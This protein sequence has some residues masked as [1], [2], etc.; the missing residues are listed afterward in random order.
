MTTITPPGQLSTAP[1]TKPG[2]QRIANVQRGGQADAAAKTASART[3]A[4]EHRSQAGEQA[5]VHRMPG[6][7]RVEAE[8]LFL[9]NDNAAARTS[10]RGQF[11]DVF[12]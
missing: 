12:T 7:R 3:L 1:G 5:R 2:L 8:A 10:N 6:N 9:Y 4:A 11:V